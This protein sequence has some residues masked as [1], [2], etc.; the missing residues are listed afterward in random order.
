[1]V[2]TEEDGFLTNENFDL[3]HTNVVTEEDGWF[4]NENICLYI[5]LNYKYIY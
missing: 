3:F 2:D 4:S 5:C 1:M